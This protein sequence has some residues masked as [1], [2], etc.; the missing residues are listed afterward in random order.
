MESLRPVYSVT[1]I[2]EEIS[3]LLSG[4]FGTV[5]VEGEISGWKVATSG[6]AYFSL[7]DER[8]LIKGVMWRSR[9][10]RLKTLPRDGQLVRATGSISV[11]GPRGEYQLDVTTLAQA[12]IGLLQQRFEELKRKLEAEGLFDPARKRHPPSPLRRIAVITSPAGAALH[13]FLRTLELHDARLEILI[14]PVRVQGLE[15][16]PEIAAALE[17]IGRFGCDLAVLTR[18]GGSLED[19]WA[20]NEEVVARAIA[21][22]PIP[23]LSAVGHEV[24][25]TIADFVADLRA[26]TPTAAAH[27]LAEE[28]TAWWEQLHD[29]ESRLGEAMQDLLE[30]RRSEVRALMGRLQA[31]SPLAVIPFYRQR[32][33]DLFGRAEQSLAHRLESGG[34]RVSALSQRLTSSIRMDILR[35]K[36]NLRTENE[37]LWVLDP[38]ATLRRGYALVET[39]A[40]AEAIRSIRDVP[41]DGDVRVHLSDGDFLAAPHS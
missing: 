14:L 37:R 6:H 4:H 33:D 26:A 12:G 24:D 28:S 23:V 16:P 25:F 13:D 21:A 22:S 19:L 39:A 2:T 17:G 10:E 31:R 40:G 8:S 36:G 29:L 32:I 1:Q 27:F 5:S 20:F 18:G 9:L 34:S 15:A 38:Q 11:Y 41:T 35:W 30:T 3:S 7:K